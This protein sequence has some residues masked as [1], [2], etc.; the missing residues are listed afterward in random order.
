MGL[1]ACCCSTVQL[2]QI[3]IVMGAVSTF[4]LQTTLKTDQC[5]VNIFQRAKSL[6]S[7]FHRY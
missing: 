7:S 4:V 2:G 3:D 6:P 1:Y 5:A